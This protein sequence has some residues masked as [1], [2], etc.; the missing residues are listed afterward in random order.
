MTSSI[1]SRD[2]TAAERLGVAGY[3]VKPSDY[4]QFVK[5]LDTALSLFTREAKRVK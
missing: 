1:S 4:E 3:L 2:R 5:N